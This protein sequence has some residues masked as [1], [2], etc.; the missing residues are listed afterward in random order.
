MALLKIGIVEDELIIASC[1]IDTLDELGYSHCGPAISYTEAVQLLN[2]EQPDLL[3]L[4]INLYGRKTGLDVAAFINE[5]HPIPFIFL[6]AYSD[7]QT[8]DRAKKVKPHA[9]IVKPFSKEELFVA[10]EIAYSNF[11]GRGDSEKEKNP[12]LFNTT[13]TLF[14]KEGLRFHKVNFND[15]LYIES[16]H[17]YVTLFLTGMRKFTVRSGITDFLQRL[18]SSAFLQVH[19]SY[20]INMQ[21]IE[22]F[23]VSDVVVQ[24]QKIPFGKTHR[25]ELMNRLG[26]TG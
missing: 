23:D 25:E 13:E 1:I 4:D 17:N 3:L 18:P 20:I 5:K 15:I 22:T 6:T 19:R 21:H 16:E 9:Y 24:G 12:V 10:I 8:I 7:A 14:V 11:T 2:D 26:I